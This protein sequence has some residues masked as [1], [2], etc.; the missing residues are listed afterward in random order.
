M[1]DTE[2]TVSH[3]VWIKVDLTG[4]NSNGLVGAMVWDRL[5]AGRKAIRRAALP[6]RPAESLLDRSCGPSNAGPKSGS[7]TGGSI[8]VS[9]RGGFVFPGAKWPSGGPVFGISS[10]ARLTI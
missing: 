7:P 4:L 8:G 5:P 2:L 3:P 1:S 10:R 9:K 6:T